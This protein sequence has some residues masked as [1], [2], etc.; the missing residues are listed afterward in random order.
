MILNI[1]KYLNN[2]MYQQIQPL[3][4]INDMKYAAY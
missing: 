4:Q 2:L 1:I 3:Q